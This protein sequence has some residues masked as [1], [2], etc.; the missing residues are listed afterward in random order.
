MTEELIEIL[1][2]ATR[3]GEVVSVRYDGGSQPGTVR[4][5]CPRDV[6][7]ETIR[8]LDV[9]TGAIKE[10]RLDK[11]R[12]ADSY[13]DQRQ[14]DPNRPSVIDSVRDIGLAIA[15]RKRELEA[16]G[17]HLQADSA[18]VALLREFKNGK[19]R[20]TPDI[21]LSFREFVVESTY[22]LRIN[23][24]IETSRLSKRPF[25]LDVRDA[26]QAH[27]FERLS[28][29]IEELFAHA[30]RLAPNQTP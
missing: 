27:A 6:S 11:L 17:W 13:A 19:L 28:V 9:A 8:A 26:E 7:D 30:K 16:L 15:D 22:D 20:K 2:A 12:L 5:I 10:F 24:F 18:S 21:R 14:Y 3:S 23:D 25:R 4:G 1:R 29:A